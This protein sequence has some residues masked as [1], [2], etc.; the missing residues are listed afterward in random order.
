MV[1]RIPFAKRRP[2]R[3]ALMLMA[4][5]VACGSDDDGN[6][7][8][9]GPCGPDFDPDRASFVDDGGC[10]EFSINCRS[11]SAC[12]VPDEPE[13]FFFP[14]RDPNICIRVVCASNND[15]EA[16]QECSPEN[17]CRP[18]V[19]QNTGDCPPGQVCLGGSCGTA[20]AASE[21]DTC[22]V[23]TRATT[24]KEGQTLA[25]TA[26]ARD[27]SGAPLPWITFQWTSSDPAVVGVADAQA[28]GGTLAGTAEL[29]ARPE[30]QSDLCE[31]AASV[32][33]F[34]NIASGTARVVV[35]ADFDGSPVATASV[36]IDT[37][38]AP[39]LTATTS[40]AGVALFA[41]PGPVRS[42]TVHKEG[43][44]VVSVLSPGTN[45]ILIPLPRAPDATVA[46]GF[47]GV[48]D[49]S[50]TPNQQI[51][52]GFVGPAL[53][54]NLLDLDLTGLLGDL[55]PTVID[56]PELM[57]NNVPVNLPGGLLLGIGNRTFTED[58]TRCEGINPSGDQLGCFVARAP[59]GRTAAWGLGGQL[60]LTALTG[61]AG[62]L[63]ELLGGGGDVPVGDLLAAVLP[64]VRN[65]NHA[66]NPSL[67]VEEFPRVNGQADLARFGRVD[68]A[69][70][71]PQS[72]LS[73]VSVPDMPFLV[74]TS[75]TCGT[76]GGGTV[77]I[78]GALLEGRGIVPLGLVAGLDTLDDSATPDCRVEG[79]E[80][81]FGN[82]SDPLPDGQV[83]LSMAPL[84]SGMEGSQV[85][86]LA[87]ALDLDRL[88]G[89]SLEFSVLVRRV[90][91][92]RSEE[93]FTGGY[94][95][96]PE[97]TVSRSAATVQFRSGVSGQTMVRAELQ[98]GNRTWLIYAPA[99]ETT[100]NL[101]D[102]PEG[103]AVLAGAQG[104]LVMTIGTNGS[105]PEVWTFGSGGTLDRL[106]ETLTSFAIQDCTATATA[107][108]AAR[109]RTSDPKRAAFGRLGGWPT[110][111]V[112]RAGR[113]GTSG[114]N[115]HAVPMRDG[116]SKVRMP[117]RRAPFWRRISSPCGGPTEPG[118]PSRF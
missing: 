89:G 7:A 54:S 56:A 108:R 52:V 50:G 101:P 62:Q 10:C 79:V 95:V 58:Q 24:L 70:D 85:F 77:V 114:G 20:P 37:G 55:L 91:A 109:F 41:T 88:T 103:R 57:L 96:Q 31:G 100:L 61:I 78:G 74:G 80:E 92:V 72:I 29:T 107:G 17:L 53:P 90:D 105:Y 110:R 117:S 66:V 104:G 115:S 60:P 112:P 82:R 68:L 45:D 6:G 111:R 15:C 49:L 46:G 30:G 14:D 86:L 34:T 106:V 27:A 9:T 5:A 99:S 113:C 22:E 75:T 16:G 25:L 28:T 97:G 1:N 44:D 63:A 118:D 19:C 116:P 3:A 13:G 42:V 59:A 65:L 2:Y 40:A 94:P 23:I 71:A 39:I 11:G 35:L 47:R 81:P 12:N 64:L 33:N 18:P 73:A 51:K 84:H 38:T 98:S 32:V 83:P 69:V 87:A 93:S 8:P 48:V 36:A 4:L 67:T 102:V 26:V 76:A 43:W 21:V